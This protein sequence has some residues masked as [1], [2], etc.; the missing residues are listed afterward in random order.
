MKKIIDLQK[1]LSLEM[2]KLK[3]TSQQRRLLVKNYMTGQAA[4][5][6]DYLGHSIPSLRGILKKKLSV[7]STDLQTQY[8]VFEK[9]WF[10]A[11]TFDQKALSLFWL[12][13]LSKDELLQIAKPLLKWSSI[14]DNWAHSDGLCSTYSKI[15]EL[16]PS[17]YLAT[18]KKWN[19][20]KN[21]WLRRISMVGL[22]YYS[23]AR[24]SHPRFQL[25]QEFVRP[26]FSASE[27][28]VQKAVGWTLREMYNVYPKETLIWIDKNV[29]QISSIAWVAA[30][31]KLPL[32]TKKKL[33]QKR[34]LKS[35]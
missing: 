9:N 33:L 19:K 3:P 8:L 29:H 30:S 24:R 13:S 7:H 6:M 28:Y 32:A 22:I 12:D 5:N 17:L 2:K 16:N 4:S 1:E 35:M 23:R 21:P 20:H 34:K 11:E 10:T 18:Y 15:F 27:Y 26:H 31:E 25:A 14:I